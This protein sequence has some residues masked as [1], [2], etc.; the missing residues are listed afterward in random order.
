M[1]LSDAILFREQFKIPKAF[2][3]FR[4]RRIHF[5]K[6]LRSSA[7]R[8][9]LPASEFDFLLLSSENALK[10]VRQKP[11]AKR[12]VQNL[13]GDRILA[14]FKKQR[15]KGASILYLRSDLGASLGRADIVPSLRRL[16][17]RVTVR[18]TYRTEI[19]RI[20]PRLISLL[21]RKPIGA[22]MVTSP[23]T[24]KAIRLALTAREFSALRVRWICMG[25]TTRAYLHRYL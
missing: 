19:L 15:S 25:S 14:F 13:H 10:F 23:S 1:S 5:C 4:F 18:C 12:V 17:F 6:T 3:G 8:V 20:R 7:R 22:L 2:Q 24:V 16:G 11:K 21:R 9:K